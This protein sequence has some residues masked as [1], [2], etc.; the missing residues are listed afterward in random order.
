MR[1][2]S[3]AQDTHAAPCARLLH[4]AR[5]FRALMRVYSHDM[6]HVQ[7]DAFCGNS[8]LHEAKTLK[9]FL[10]EANAH[11][12]KARVWHAMLAC[13]IWLWAGVNAATAQAALISLGFS[14]MISETFIENDIPPATV[15]WGNVTFDSTSASTG[16]LQPDVDLYRFELSL[17]DAQSH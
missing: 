14:G 12:A 3:K 13:S 5:I 6:E 8:G 16:E 9:A 4:R 17:C 2:Q 11:P 7:R 10:N 1:T 15:F